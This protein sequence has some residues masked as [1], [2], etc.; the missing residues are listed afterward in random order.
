MSA[1]RTDI[2]KWSSDAAALLRCVPTKPLRPMRHTFR[3][4]PIVQNS[5]HLHGVTPTVLR[6]SQVNGRRTDGIV[7]ECGLHWP[8]RG[9]SG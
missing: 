3:A 4:I 8:A 5:T 9:A 7:I 6:V 2:V 1:D